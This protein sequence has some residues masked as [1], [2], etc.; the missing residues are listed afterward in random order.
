MNTIG[1]Q[2][3]NS[4]LDI[5]SQSCTT[6][7]AAVTGGTFHLQRA[8]ISV[9]SVTDGVFFNVCTGTSSAASGSVLFSV[10]G[11]VPALGFLDFGEKGY[12]MGNGYALY[13][14]VTGGAIKVHCSVLGYLR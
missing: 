10:S 7:M 5:T 6:I 8:V 9:A 14:N 11:S 3:H 12:P 2:P 4:R 1:Y 13:Y